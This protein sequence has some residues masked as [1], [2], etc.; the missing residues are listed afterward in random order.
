MDYIYRS[1]SLPIYVY[2]PKTTCV[3]IINLAMLAWR[4]TDATSSSQYR[5]GK[6][7]FARDVSTAVTLYPC[8]EMETR[9]TIKY[10]KLHLRWENRNPTQFISVYTR[11]STAE[12]EARRR[13]E[14]GEKDVTIWEVDLTSDD[15]EWA[16]MYDLKN[17]LGFWIRENAF[18]NA[19]HEALVLHCIPRHLVIRGRRFTNPRGCKYPSSDIVEG[20]GLRRR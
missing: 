13:M 9:A 17:D 16:K 11:Y 15:L 1:H 8:T 7:F 5:R 10:I 6:G 18:H 12:N 2:S 4:V 19:K 3:S 20:Q 14:A